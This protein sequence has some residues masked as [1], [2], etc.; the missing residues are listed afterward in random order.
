VGIA[1]WAPPPPFAVFDRPAWAAVGRGRAPVG[2]AP[3]PGS[4]LD[5]AEWS[6]VYVPLAHLLGIH[7]DHRVELR[8]HSEAAGWRG[9]GA[10]P[11]V[12]A[13]AGSVA[14]GK[15][16]CAQALAALMAVRPSRPAVTVIGTD[17]FLL[18]NAELA[19]RGLLPRKGFPESYDR[20]LVS[21]VLGR[22]ALGDDEVE[23][24]RYSHRLYDITDE[25]VS[26]G[27]PDVLIVEGVNALDPAIADFAS[28]L[29]YL[30]ADED[31]LRAW[32]A[33]RMAALVADA[34]GEPHSFFSGWVGMDHAQIEQLASTVWEQVNG[35]NLREH[36]LPTRWRADIVLR[37][38]P[39]HT[40][41]D[42]AIRLR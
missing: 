39:G 19:A 33:A 27:R 14:V 42:V 10:G 25:R 37:K 1:A 32:F 38:G 26:L 12:I 13:L 8:R 20:A 16:T 6:E 21:D 18:T 41:T 22:V 4:P 28:L 11:M 5:A 31:E 7:L 29:V 24:P 36:I 35:V 34:A 9:V 40:V 30:D 23:V 3:P 2:A 17:G 15:S